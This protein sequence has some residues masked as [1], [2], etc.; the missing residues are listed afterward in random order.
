MVATA[1][2]T[3]VAA[4][5]S[6]SL[7]AH[8]EF[9]RPVAEFDPI[10]VPPAGDSI[11]AWGDGLTWPAYI[12]PYDDVEIVFGF[13]AGGYKIGDIAANTPDCACDIVVVMA[14]TNDMGSESW[15]TPNGATR[16]VA[17]ANSRPVGRGPRLDPCCPP[18]NIGGVWVDRWNAE[19]Q[20]LAAFYSWNYFDPWASIRT[21][22]NSYVPGS[23]FD[24]AHPTPESQQAAAVLIHEAILA[25]VR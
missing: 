19:Q 7:R 12:D 6:S 15:E 1:R 22:E 17:G 2:I 20:R 5:S 25:A 10:A 3:Q 9:L 16:R 14:G 4:T 24:N 21:P 11:T 8:V 23:N 13:A 18:I